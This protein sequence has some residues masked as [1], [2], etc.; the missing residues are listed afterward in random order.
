MFSTGLAQ[1]LCF[2]SVHWWWIFW[3]SLFLWQTF[4]SLTVFG[5]PILSMFW[6]YLKNVKPLYSLR[7]LVW[8]EVISIFYKSALFS[9]KFKK[10]C[11]LKGPCCVKDILLLYFVKVITRNY[12]YIINITLNSLNYKPILNFFCTIFKASWMLLEFRLLSSTLFLYFAYYKCNIS[13]RL[14]PI[15]H[16]LLASDI[17]DVP[18]CHLNVTDLPQVL[19]TITIGYLI[20]Y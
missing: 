20:Y 10:Y 13:W 16:M 15:A 8:S 3:P 18:F 19:R 14:D 12:I 6:T 4:T 5:E 7:F 2:G 17:S 1:G 9:L 11:Q